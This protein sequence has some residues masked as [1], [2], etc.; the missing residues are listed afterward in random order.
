MVPV[1]PWGKFVAGLNALVRC[2]VEGSYEY[3][4]FS[5]IETKVTNEGI[6]DLQSQVNI[7][8]LSLAFR[9][10]TSLPTIVPLSL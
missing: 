8:S 2:A 4:L 5:S 6:S 9:L 7:P 10:F 3:I 1:S